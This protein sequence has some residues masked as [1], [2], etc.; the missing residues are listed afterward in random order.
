MKKSV[1][2][3]NSNVDQAQAQV[4]VKMPFS[5]RAFRLVFAILCRITPTLAA[6]WAD[7]IFFDP[8]AKPRPAS[9]LSWYAAAN[10]TSLEF[11]GQQVA[12]YEWGKGPKTILVVHGWGSRGTR[13]GHLAGPLNKLG[14]RVVAFDALGHGDSSGKVTNILEIAG[15]IAAL[16]EKYDPIQAMIGHSLGGMAISVALVRHRLEIS[17]LAIVASPLSMKYIFES[18]GQQLNLTAKVLELLRIRVVER[19]RRV[20]GVEIDQLSPDVLIPKITVP[21]IIFHDQ[22][23]REV[24]LHQAEGYASGLPNSQLVVTSG[25]G[26]RRIL[27][28]PEIVRQ[29]VAFITAE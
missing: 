29:L 25:L 18:F 6:R 23:D 22:S 7:R 20:Y 24:A 1:T 8:M 16:H 9:E 17:R 11:N 2:A 5:M 10:H 15:V 13:L 3:A 4:P 14:Y 27:R 19:F 12:V 26:H 28:D 21:A